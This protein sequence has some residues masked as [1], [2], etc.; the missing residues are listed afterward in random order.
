MDI[1]I[2]KIKEIGKII[3]RKISPCF[4]LETRWH[5][6]QISEKISQDKYRKKSYF[7]INNKRWLE[8]MVLR[9]FEI[10]RAED[11][12]NKILIDIGSGPTG[13]LTRL[14]AKEKIAVDPLPID[15]TDPSIKRIKARGEEIPLDDQTADCVFLYNVL[16]HVMMPEKVLDEGLRILKSGGIFYILEQLNLPTDP[17]HPHSLKLEM[18]D[19]WISK[20]NFKIIKKTVENDCDLNFDQSAPGS[21]YA[22]LC[23]ILV[24]QSKME[25]RKETE[26]NIENNWDIIY[27]NYKDLDIINKQ[28][29]SKLAKVLEKYI[30]PVDSILEAGCGSGY[31]VSY[32]QKQGHYSVGLDSHSQP[33]EVARKVFGAENLKKGDLFDLPFENSSFDIV[34]NEGVLEH[35]KINKSIE[36]AKEMAR[37]SKKYVIIDVPNRYSPFAPAVMIKKMIGKWPYGYRESYSVA[38][39]KYLMEQAGL[40]V[41][42]VHGVYLAP[43]LGFLP[44]RIVLK[45]LNVL[46][47]IED[48]HP[49]L[50]I[51]F[52]YHLVMVGR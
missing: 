30:K 20:N 40:E 52:G 17:S 4:S 24:K 34:W 37:V 16:Q 22:V 38:R 18:F 46:G 51:L 43:P 35:F 19:N 27:R 36:A 14:Q 6:A 21:G 32:F 29:Y 1:K 42:G 15:S 10:K 9:Y 49:K 31:M 12:K 2:K 7:A 23:L 25:E 33:L 41:L 39:L 13:I 8:E 44:Q 48:N 26:N 45:I 5:L 3:Y 47:K 11:F 50:T 28:I